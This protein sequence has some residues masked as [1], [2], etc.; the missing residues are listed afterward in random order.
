[1]DATVDS[2]NIVCTDTAI[3]NGSATANAELP[4][5]FWY[6]SFEDLSNG[7][8][9]DNGASSWSF[10]TSG[11]SCDKNAIIEVQTNQ[12]QNRFRVQNSDCEV[13]WSTGIIDIS[14]VSDVGAS[15]DLYSKGSFNGNS[16]FIEVY[17]SLDGG[18]LQL[19][20]NGQHSGPLGNG[21]KTAKIEGLNGNT[22][23]IIVKA[24]NNR[25]SEEY[26]WDNL[27]IEA[28]GPPATGVTYN[29][30]EGNSP[31]GPIVFTGALV[32]NMIHGNYTVIAIDDVTGCLSNPALVIIDST[33]YNVPGAYVQ[34]LSPFTNCALPY[35]GALGAGIFD[36][37]DTLTT[38]YFYEWY[39][40][41]DPKIPSFIQRTGAIANNLESREYSV[42]ITDLATGCDTT[43]TAE[44]VNEVVIPTVTAYNNRACHFLLE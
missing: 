1:M 33:G 18:A 14:S 21:V 39:H 38:G 7:Q 8:T 37:T 12:G 35:D 5:T 42:I 17:Y 28:I 3:S 41:E 27:I 2:P 23:Q 15:L 22:L 16:D 13:E 26:F 10:S 44:V 25:S 36:G 4:G 11:G 40:Q 19:F 29:W 9:S 24:K 6:E 30:Y 34:Q 43:L 32:N 31:T 20:D